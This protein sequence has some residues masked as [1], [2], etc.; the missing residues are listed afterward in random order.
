MCIG[1]VSFDNLATCGKCTE[2]I[3]R[4]GDEKDRRSGGRWEI[5]C[6]YTNFWSSAG[7]ENNSSA[8]EQFLQ[9]HVL[10]PEKKAVQ[11]DI[12]SS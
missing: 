7:G 12:I 3:K 9:V 5:R 4:T 11:V 10:C 1:P 2:Q 8:D 6:T